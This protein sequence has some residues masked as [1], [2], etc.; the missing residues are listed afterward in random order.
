MKAAALK[1]PEAVLSATRMTEK[2]L[3]VELAAHLFEA[4]K[5]SIGK[6]KE[7]AGMTLWEFQHFL[8]S[9]KIPVRYGIKDYREDIKTL[10]ALKRIK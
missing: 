3:S 8:A 5:L 9:R 1:I 6:A 4:G 7:L 2:E 10:K